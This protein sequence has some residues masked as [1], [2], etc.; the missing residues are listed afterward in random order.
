MKIEEWIIFMKWMTILS[1]L[2][3]LIVFS[4]SGTDDCSLCDFEIDGKGCGINEFMNYYDEE[5]FGPIDELEINITLNS[6]N[7]SSLS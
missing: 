4:V 1:G 7:L 6:L 2:I 5:C 3:F